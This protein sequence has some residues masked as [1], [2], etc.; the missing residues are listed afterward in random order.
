MDWR[1]SLLGRTF[2]M[3][4]RSIYNYLWFWFGTH[5][6]NIISSVLADG[7]YH[8]VCTLKFYKCYWLQIT[9]RPL[10]LQET[11]RRGTP[12]ELCKYSFG[13][14]ELFKIK[15][16]H[17]YTFCW[18]GDALTI[19]K[20]ATQ[21]VLEHAIRLKFY[22]NKTTPRWSSLNQNTYHLQP[23]SNLLT[24]N[25]THRWHPPTR[26]LTCTLKI[27]ASTHTSTSAWFHSF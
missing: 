4:S 7:G 21:H 10:V 25:N 22:T 18:M 14:T 24:V 9:S 27:T 16:P 17:T 5:E 8:H 3:L 26:V 2:G 13:E 11:S 23:L 12:F 1:K 15:Y 19:V 6:F 20:V